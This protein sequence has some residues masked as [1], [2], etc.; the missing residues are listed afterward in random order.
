[1]SVTGSPA[2][3]GKATYFQNVFNYYG[4]ERYAVQFSNDTAAAN[5]FY[6]TYVY[7]ANDSNGI[8]N[9]EFDL[10]QT[11]QNGQTV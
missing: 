1:M 5:F 7:I 2:P 4:G 8:S 6:D 9:L 3:D 11:M 10:A